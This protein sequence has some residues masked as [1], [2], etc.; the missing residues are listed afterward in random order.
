[1]ATRRVIA[2]RVATEGHPYSCSPSHTEN[3]RAR[4]RTLLYSTLPFPRLLI[5]PDLASFSHP[6]SP[7]ELNK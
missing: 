5:S 2:E 4:S 3:C 1:V 7:G 6:G